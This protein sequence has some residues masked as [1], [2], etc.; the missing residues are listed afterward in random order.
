M[1]Y[2]ELNEVNIDLYNLVELTGNSKKAMLEK[3]REAA[4]TGHI[5]SVNVPDEMII[6]QNIF[7]QFP[8]EVIDEV[9]TVEQVPH[10]EEQYPCIFT[11]IVDPH[12][13]SIEICVLHGQPSSRPV[14]PGSNVPCQ[15]LLPN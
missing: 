15:A 11:T 10:E 1:A 7:E 12:Q 8:A 3:A 5:L 9:I 4:E 2:V 6:E 13:G 14:T